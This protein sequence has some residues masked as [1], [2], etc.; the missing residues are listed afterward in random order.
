MNAS[1]FCDEMRALKMAALHNLLVPGLSFSLVLDSPANAIDSTQAK[2][3]SPRPLP[4]HSRLTGRKISYQNF[5]A[6]QEGKDYRSQVWLAKPADL[7]SSTCLVFKF[8]VASHLP[9]Q[10][11]VPEENYRSL[12]QVV[13]NQLEPFEK[14]YFLQGSY[15]PWFFGVHEVVVPD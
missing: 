12:E 7:E 11:E 1:A 14:L 10:D 15:L 3:Y 4:L 5:Q 8:I 9:Q 6:I 2:G 13:T